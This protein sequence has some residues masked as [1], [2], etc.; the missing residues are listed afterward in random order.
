MCSVSMLIPESSGD[1][2][3]GSKQLDMGDDSVRGSESHSPA[4]ADQQ[5]TEKDSLGSHNVENY[6]DVGLVRDNGPS[7]T[8]ETI[9][10]QDA[11]EL[12]SF[13][14]CADFFCQLHLCLFVLLI[15]IIS[16]VVLF[17]IINPIFFN[18]LFLLQA[19]L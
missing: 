13:S 14:V 16:D 3:V 7:Y 9:P 6:A 18:C 15:A 19:E 2:N 1:E 5:L 11:S 17:C 12:R 8:P 10:Q 4:S